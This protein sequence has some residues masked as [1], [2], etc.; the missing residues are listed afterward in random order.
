MNVFLVIGPLVIVGLTGFIA[1]TSRWLTKEQIDTLSKVTFYL[2]IPAFLFRQL[3]TTD[4]HN[5]DLTVYAAFYFPVIAIHTIA[6]LINYYFHQKSKNCTS[7]SA[8]FALGGELL[9]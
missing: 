7:S 6:W 1:S 2:C 9:Q 5:F 8:T 4:L 3:A